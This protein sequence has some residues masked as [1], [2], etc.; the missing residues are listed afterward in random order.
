MKTNPVKDWRIISTWNNYN[1]VINLHQDDET[2]DLCLMEYDVLYEDW[3]ELEYFD[4]SPNA[5]LIAHATFLEQ[6]LDHIGEDV[7]YNYES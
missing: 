4:N 1:Y 7:Y 3:D 6:I 5:E 2:G